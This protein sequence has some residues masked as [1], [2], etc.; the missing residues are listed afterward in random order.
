MQAWLKVNQ[1]L[2]FVDISPEMVEVIPLSSKNSLRSMF[3]QK[4][5]IINMSNILV[6][7]VTKQKSSGKLGSAT[8]D[9]MDWQSVRSDSLVGLWHKNK[10]VS[11]ELL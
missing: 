6:C 5:T 9:D 2:L 10:T 3:S 4:T 1:S 11:L 7:S 8:D